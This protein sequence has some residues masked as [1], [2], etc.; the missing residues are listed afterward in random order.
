[1]NFNPDVEVQKHSK[2]LDAVV[3]NAP[4]AALTTQLT[5]ITFTAPDTPDYALQDLTA[6][7]G[8]GFKTKDGLSIR[9]SAKKNASPPESV[10]TR[11]EETPARFASAAAASS[12]AEAEAS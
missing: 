7:G 11:C 8:Y 2:I 12:P 1:M 6:S 5:T 10:L 4:G 3:A 9:R